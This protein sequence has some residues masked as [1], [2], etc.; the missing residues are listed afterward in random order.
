MRF[1]SDNTADAW[2]LDNVSLINLNTSNTEMLVN[3]NFEQGTMTGWGVL[4]SSNCKSSASS[5]QVS[6]SGCYAGSYC[7]R[8]PCEDAYDI[9]KQEFTKTAGHVYELSFYLRCSCDSGQK[10][11]VK[12]H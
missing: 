11:Y 3:G 5:G 10:A 1:F 4:C 8:D 9:L 2:M 7:Y 12:L 6:S